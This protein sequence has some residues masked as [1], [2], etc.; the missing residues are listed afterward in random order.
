MQPYFVPYPGYFRLMQASDIFVI[1][2]CVQFPRRGYVHRN[3]L[4]DPLGK[5]KWLTLPLLKQKRSIKIKDLLFN[6]I[7]INRFIKQLENDA[8]YKKLSA[9]TELWDRL[10]NFNQAPVEYIVELI[11]FIC[12]I[13]NIK[14]RF[15][16]SSDLNI[17][18]SLKG[19]E[20]IISIVKALNGTNYINA[21]N[22][23]NLYRFEDFQKHGIELSFLN[24]FKGSYLSVLHSLCVNDIDNLSKI[25]KKQSNL[26][27]PDFKLDMHAAGALA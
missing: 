8:I 14:T 3:K 22:G 11:K 10:T 2:D 23:K 13:L 12:A 1:Y 17:D 25:I 6:P 20:R 19:Q 26:V 24:D 7:E 4:I 16:Y 5:E 9:R 27:A 21:P 15:V 18:N